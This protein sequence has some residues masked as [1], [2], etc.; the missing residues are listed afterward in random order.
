MIEFALWLVSPGKDITDKWY[1][2][3]SRE[4]LNVKPFPDLSAV[5]RIPQDTWGLA[6][7]EIC[8][9][10]VAEPNDLKVFLSGRKNIS[11]IVFGKSG[12]ITNSQISGFLE[13][14]ADDFITTD[15]NEN[16]LLSKTKAH[17]RRILPSLNSA[18]MIIVSQNGGIELDRLKRTVK[19]DFKA[20]K[21][22]VIESLTPK[23]FDILTTFL[24]KEN[25]VVSRSSLMEGVWKERSGEVNCETID[26]HVETLRRKLGV[27]GKNIRTIYGTGYM[28]KSE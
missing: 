22:K 9:E 3:F 27:Y 16:V 24:C 4:R 15:I 1:R 26:K 10:G 8:R 17:I 28:Y 12:K 20:K 14:G 23:E 11:V 25:E 7:V 18:R 13:N 6:F 5:S 21:E 2:L 19:T